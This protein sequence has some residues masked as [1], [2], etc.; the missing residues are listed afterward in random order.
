MESA[1]FDNAPKKSHKTLYVAIAIIA[2]I[3]IAVGV[4]TY[5][6]LGGVSKENGSVQ[7]SPTASPTPVASNE[8][9]DQ[10]LQVLDAAIS[11][12]S[13]DQETAKEAI[14]D[15]ATPTKLGE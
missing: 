10:E 9:V 8:E 2:V 4:A 3:A 6:L 11:V 14:K 7:G 5:M 15:G 1:Q 12:A 13:S